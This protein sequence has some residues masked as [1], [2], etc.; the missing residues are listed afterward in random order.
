M[1]VHVNVSSVLNY[2]QV[3]KITIEMDTRSGKHA[4]LNFSLK[5]KQK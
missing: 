3:T 2:I 4:F 5:L 1:S